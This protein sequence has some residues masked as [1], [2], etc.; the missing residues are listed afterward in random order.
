MLELAP[1]TALSGPEPAEHVAAVTPNT[2]AV[3]A[4]CSATSVSV[5]AWAT[6]PT[7]SVAATVA[8][9]TP[10]FTHRYMRIGCPPSGH[11]HPTT[12]AVVPASIRPSLT[13]KACAVLARHCA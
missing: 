4:A 13:R 9:E 8:D 7:D 2:V 5:A 12:F 6:P 11:P 3:V 1:S 10:S